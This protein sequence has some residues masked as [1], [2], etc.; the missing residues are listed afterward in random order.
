MNCSVILGV[1]VLSEQYISSDQVFTKDKRD[2]ATYQNDSSEGRSKDSLTARNHH[3][4][5]ENIG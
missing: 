4:A 2:H 3:G 5:S 1:V